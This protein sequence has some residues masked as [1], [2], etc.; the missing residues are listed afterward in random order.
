MKSYIVFFIIISA[1]NSAVAQDKMIAVNDIRKAGIT[2]H[3]HDTATAGHSAGDVLVN[4][5]LSVKPE[6]FKE[7][8]KKDT[9]D[10]YQIHFFKMYE[11]KLMN[12]G[13]SYS[14]DASFDMVS[15][16]WLNDTIVSITLINSGTKEN[17]SLQL[18]QSG[19]T[20]GIMKESLK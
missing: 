17:R 16:H 4:R 2:K 13:F 15:Y 8:D 3:D 19:N 20:A 14:D 5:S 9:L 1:I 10:T 18:V 6:Y 12:Y 7:K 11:N